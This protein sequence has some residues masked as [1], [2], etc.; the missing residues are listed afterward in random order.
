MKYLLIGGV[1]LLTSLFYKIF[2]YKRKSSFYLKETQLIT[3]K[4]SQKDKE[5]FLKNNRHPEDKE[6]TLLINKSGCYMIDEY[7]C[8]KDKHI[9]QVYTNSDNANHNFYLEL[10]N[11]YAMCETNLSN[12]KATNIDCFKRDW[13][14]IHQ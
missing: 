7:Q 4:I 6:I 14:H 12:G 2:D 8:Q 3:E 13:I 5:F 11:N 9:Y 10:Y 1:L